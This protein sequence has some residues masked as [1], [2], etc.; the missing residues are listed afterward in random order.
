MSTDAG[1]AGEG[2]PRR[3]KIVATLGPAT[4][5]P[6]A[7]AALIEAGMDVAR[8][9]L[10]HGSRREHEAAIDDVRAAAGLRGTAVAVLL[11]LPG[12]KLRLGDLDEPLSVH[13]GQVLRM[14]EGAGADVPVNFPGL[15]T[16]FRA[17]ELV[18]VDDGAMALRVRAVSPS[19]VS[20]EALDD[21]VLRSRKGVNVP[22]TRLPIGALTDADRELVAWGLTQDADYFAL[23]FVRSGD[24]VTEL[25]DLIAA[26]GGDQLVVAKIEKKEA[27]AAH[28]EI[29]GPPTP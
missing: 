15:L 1:R 21:G 8:I 27:L 2:V 10:S 24:D 18:L 17:G 3:T 20:L 28:E 22:D 23:S 12:P 16:H 19:S 5:G 13:R 26:G 11:D 4:S 29:I 7:V 25:K 9:N 6:R 14:G